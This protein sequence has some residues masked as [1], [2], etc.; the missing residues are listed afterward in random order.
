LFLS[1]SAAEVNSQIHRV[2]I[3][4]IVALVCLVIG[5]GVKAF[6]TSRGG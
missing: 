6:M 1:W 4:D 3:A 2:V 5:S